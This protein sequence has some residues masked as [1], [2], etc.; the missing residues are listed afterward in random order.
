MTGRDLVAASLR[1]IGAIAP[2]ESPEA[3]EATDG[4]YALNR[5]ISSWSTERLLIYAQVREEFTLTPGQAAYT[6]GSGANFDSSRPISI[7]KASIQSLTSPAIEY[8][9]RI[10]SQAQWAEVVLKGMQSTIP[11]D[12][13]AEG[14]YPNETINLYPV[15]SEANRLVLYTHK[16]LTE[17]ASLDTSISFPPGYE[18]ALVSNGALELAPEYGKA[19]SAELVRMADDSRA[20]IKRANIRANYLRVESALMGSR[21]FDIF[22]GDTT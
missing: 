5:M 12:L 16:P 1:L 3:S 21:P 9:I 10:L 19:A 13:F 6:M 20:A 22:K 7:E 2:G 18:R 15:P 11:T 8:P 17:I 4:L 14:T